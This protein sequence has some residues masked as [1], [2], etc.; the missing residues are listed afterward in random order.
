MRLRNGSGPPR[1]SS[2]EGLEVD[3]LGL[4]LADHPLHGTGGEPLLVEAELG[5]DH[6]DHATRVRVVVDRE[7]RAVAQPVGVGAQ[8]AQ[9]GGVE[10]RDPHLLGRRSHQLGHPG[11]HLVGGLVGERDGEDP[12]RRRVPGGQE[13]GDAAREDP[14]LARAGPGDDEQRAAPVL[15]CGALGH[16]QVVEQRG[17][18]AREGTR[19]GGGAA[20]PSPPVVGTLQRER[21]RHGLGLHHLRCGGCTHA[22]VGGVE[23]LA[24]LAVSRGCG[25]SH[26][27]V[28]GGFDVTSSATRLTPSTSLMMREAM[29]STRS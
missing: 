17:G 2:R 29:R 11:A 14:R 25:H 13:V 22:L 16:G 10:R 20:A 12:P 8:D 23:Q 9:A 5:G 6:L 19:R 28:P 3:Q 27:M 7:G 21:S 15:D 18:P 4:G 24:G 1:A 26:S